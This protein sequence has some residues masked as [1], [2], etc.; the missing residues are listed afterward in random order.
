M[1]NGPEI[2]VYDIECSPNLVYAWSLWDLKVGINQIVEPQDIISFAAHKIGTKTIETHASWDG[3][4]AMLNRLHEIMD[5]A[6]YMVG[7]NHA[8]FDNKHV[9]AAFAKAGMP[10]PAPWRDIDLLRVVKKNFR[11]P[12]HKLEYVCKALNLDAKMQTGGFELW[13]ACM[14]GDQKAQRKMLRYNKMD[15]QITT[16]LYHRLLPYVEGLNVPLFDSGGT[17]TA[18]DPASASC[19]RCGGNRIHS[20]GWAYTTTTRYRR[21]QCKGCGGWMRAAK[22][23]PVVSAVLRNG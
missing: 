16:Q 18:T 14:N 15:V 8:G 6:D 11:F 9:R 12:S 19:T 20:K 21:F 2:W 4:E 7:Y 13:T 23:E 5:G 22:S 3:Y 17:G 10:P 1:Q